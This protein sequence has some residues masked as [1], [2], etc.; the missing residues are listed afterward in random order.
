MWKIENI[1]IFLL[2]LAVAL[3]DSVF[4]MKINIW[5]KKEGKKYKFFLITILVFVFLSF[6]LFPL[7]YIWIWCV[8]ACPIY[9]T[10]CASVCVCMCV[11]HIRIIWCDGKFISSFIFEKNKCSFYFS[12]FFL[13][14]IFFLLLPLQPYR[15]HIHISIKHFHSYFNW[16]QINNILK[17]EKCF[18]FC[19][20]RRSSINF[21]QIFY[22]LYISTHVLSTYEYDGIYIIVY[23]CSG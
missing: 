16:R 21:R 3:A 17:T 5:W 14:S 8:C 13:F 1:F 2:F 6:F 11:I 18:I 10:N 22:F 12:L 23:T 20:G 7:E 19:E 15:K 4:K 9:F